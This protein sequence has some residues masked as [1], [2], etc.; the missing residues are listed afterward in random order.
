MT[1]FL[2]LDANG[3]AIPALRLMDDGAHTIN[4]TDISARN[5]TAFD[6]NTRVVSLYATGPVY[7]R[8]G[9]SSVTA[10][11]TDHYFPAGVYYDMAVAG[12]GGKDSHVAALRVDSDC[13]L[14]ISE[15]Q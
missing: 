8:F 11:S 10:G 6:A 15:K 9:D 14:Y 1:T 7:L 13:T 2:P 5:S 3:N 12:P 4:V